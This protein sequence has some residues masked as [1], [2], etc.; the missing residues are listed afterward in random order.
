MNGIFPLEMLQP[1][2]GG[3]LWMYVLAWFSA[4]HPCSGMS[5]TCLI[6]DYALLSMEDAWDSVAREGIRQDAETK[7][8]TTWVCGPWVH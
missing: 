8:L 2:P 6:G 7:L 5:I 4:D 3:N 1:A